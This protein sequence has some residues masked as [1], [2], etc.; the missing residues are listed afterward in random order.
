MVSGGRRCARRGVNSK[1]RVFRRFAKEGKIKNPK[2]NPD[3]ELECEGALAFTTAA[4]NYS[5]SERTTSGV[6][7]MCASRVA[8]R[9]AD[10]NYGRDPIFRRS[11]A[12]I[13]PAL[14]VPQWNIFAFSREF[15]DDCFRA[16][17]A[18][19]APFGLVLRVYRRCCGCYAAYFFYTR[20]YRRDRRTAA[21]RRAFP[22]AQDPRRRTTPI[23]TI[24]LYAIV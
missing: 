4:A 17:N 24:T 9:G 7:D 2:R 3:S 20:I 6:R 19:H 11:V 8:G 23:T 15:R 18:F 12:L 10:D 16:Q 21:T 1:F 14:G 22:R 5:Q 13:P